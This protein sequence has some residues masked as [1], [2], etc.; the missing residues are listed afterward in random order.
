MTSA[1]WRKEGKFINIEDKKLF[2]I[3]T[4][5]LQTKKETLIILHGYPL[6]SFDFHAIIPLLSEYYRVVTHDHLGFG[7][8][9]EPSN[10]NYSIIEDANVTLKLWNKLNLK[11]FK[12]IAAD[13]GVMITKE[14]LSRPSSE[15]DHLHIISV[16]ASQNNTN[17]LYA[18][19]KAIDYL[20][21]NKHLPKYKE[22]LAGYANKDFLKG[23]EEGIHDIKYQQDSK[24]HSIWENFNTIEKQKEILML[25]NYT[26]EMFLYWHRWMHTLKTTDIQISFLWRRDD[27]SNMSDILLHLAT[28]SKENIKIVENKNCYLIDENPKNW[29]LMIF[30]Q[31][32]KITHHVLKKQY[33]AY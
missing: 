11:N 12:I 32:D 14:I 20:F 6:T 1:D 24:V 7:F 27:I 16:V 8:S 5:P 21:K 18:N 2:V 9:D 10:L 15:L 19:L 4:D 29:T 17:K 26:E 23:Q 25:S 13:Y 28:F 30:E 33:F 22:V 3:D 31:L